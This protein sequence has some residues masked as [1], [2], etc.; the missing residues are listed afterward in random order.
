MG[1]SWADEGTV[2]MHSGELG[3]LGCHG[4]GVSVCKSNLFSTKSKV[5]RE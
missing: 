3:G 5:E 1:N 4:T 2:G